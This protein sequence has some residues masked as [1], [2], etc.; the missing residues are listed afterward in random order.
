MREMRVRTDSEQE[1]RE[2]GKWLSQF[3]QPQDVIGLAGE[4]GTGKTVLAQGIGE[5]LKVG[6][7]VKS[8]SFTILNE[9][10]GRLPL[11]HLDLYRLVK[12]DFFRLGLDEYLS[13]DGVV[14]IEW[15]ERVKE[16]LP[17]KTIYIELDRL[18]AHSRDL[19]VH[20]GKDI[21]ADSWSRE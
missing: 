17:E 9:Y 14:V 20:S 15:A 7:R 13:R 6:E 10:N 3:L 1:T 5:G 11:Y 8:P 16:Y 18:T 12:E 19:L 2:F 4:L 21:D